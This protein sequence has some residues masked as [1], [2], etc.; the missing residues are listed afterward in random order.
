MIHFQKVF[1]TISLSGCKYLGGIGECGLGQAVSD[2]IWSLFTRPKIPVLDGTLFQRR[3]VSR[4]RS[5]FCR[6]RWA[7]H[8][9]ARGGRFRQGMAP[10]WNAVKL[11]LI[12]TRKEQKTG[13]QSNAA[14]FLGSNNMFFQWI[15]LKKQEITFWAN[16]NLHGAF[17][18]LRRSSQV[19]QKA[20]IS[21][22]VHSPKK[23]K[24]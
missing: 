24:K 6:V 20:I 18:P 10:M 22:L 16:S 5:I 13:P 12:T 9:Q 19:G 14:F 8:E 21:E 11:F 15:V 17:A 4:K 7:S 23:K 2:Q 3:H 1:L